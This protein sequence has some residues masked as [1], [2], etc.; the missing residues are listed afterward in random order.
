MIGNYKTWEV[1]EIAC[2]M[3]SHVVSE[4]VEWRSADVDGVTSGQ[5]SRPVPTVTCVAGNGWVRSSRENPR[6]PVPAGV[7]R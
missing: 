1:C 4:S 5:C 6:G 3:R 2:D 7:Y